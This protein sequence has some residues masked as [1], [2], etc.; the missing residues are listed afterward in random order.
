MKFKAKIV[1]IDENTWCIEEMLGMVYAFLLAGTKRAVL[2]DTGFGTCDYKA[3]VTSL[4]KLP[5]MVINTHGHLDHVSQNYAFDKVC[6]HADDEPVFHEHTDAA[7]RLGYIRMLLDEAKAPS[8][9]GRSRLFKAYTKNVVELPEK[10]N[11][12]HV[13]DGDE[14]DL[15]ERT[16]KIIHT[17]GHTRGSIMILDKEKR[18]LFSGD[19]LCDEGILLHFDH[20]TKVSAFL[21][22]MEKL[23]GMADQ[24]DKIF[25]SHHI[26][27][28]DSSY[29]EEY[30]QCAKD[31]ILSAEEAPAERED[32]KTDPAAGNA[33]GKGMVPPSEIKRAVR[34]HI[35]LSYTLDKL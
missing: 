13:S 1:P 26:Y 23:K 32:N 11:R 2:I 16:L 9:I 21:E 30:I 14:I 18:Y 29:I 4:T 19:M 22:T 6:L 33:K 27:P 20:S 12:V 15:G 28:I 7:V 10:D 8:F 17:P 3:I 5:V 31:L 24:W 25:P 35:S 34:G